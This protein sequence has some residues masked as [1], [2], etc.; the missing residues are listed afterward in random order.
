MN[1]FSFDLIYSC[2][3]LF[4][5]DRFYCLDL[6]FCCSRCSLCCAPFQATRI[7]RASAAYSIMVLLGSTA[8]GT[9]MAQSQTEAYPGLACMAIKIKMR[10]LS[11]APQV[12][13]LL[14]EAS[15]MVIRHSGSH[16]K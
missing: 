11:V 3:S 7:A 8:M 13:K 4:S 2:L 12:V 5:L 1:S 9:G 15:H 6:R 14:H 10:G 16:L